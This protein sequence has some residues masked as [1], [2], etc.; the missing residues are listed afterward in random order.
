MNRNSLFIFS[1]AGGL[2][3]G[4]AWTSWCPGLVL[5]ISFTPFLLIGEHIYRKRSDYNSGCFFLCLLPGMLIF[6]IMTLGWVRAINMWSVFTVLILA[7]FLMSFTI[8]ISYMTRIYA[9]LIPS[10][11]MFVSSRM[12]LETLAANSAILSPWVN[13]GNGLAKD[14]LFIQWYDITGVS[15]G[16]LWILI[17]NILFA[18]LIITSFSH[19]KLNIKMLLIWLMVLFIPSIYSVLKFRSLKYSDSD[20]TGVLIVQPNFDPVS[21]KYTIPFIDQLQ[22]TIDMAASNIAT[23]T[24]WVITPE[25]IVDDPINEEDADNNIYIGMLREF[26]MQHPGVNIIAGL[27]TYRDTI[28]LMDEPP[29]PYSGSDTLYYNSAA[30]IDTGK[31]VEFYHKSKLVPGVEIEFHSIIGSLV[32]IIVPELGGTTW[33]YTKQSMISCFRHS[34]TGQVAGPIICYESVYGDYV[35]DYVRQGA[36]VLVIITNDGWWKNTNGYKHHLYYAS[37]RAIET[38]RPVVRA[39]N[40]GISCFIDIKGLRVSETGWWTREVLTGSIGSET[41]VTPYVLYGDYLYNFFSI[42]FGLAFLYTLG[43]RLHKKSL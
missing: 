35:R 21:E 26:A 31:I 13:L 2:L 17:S 18:V 20:K 39:A 30:K 9:G 28:G 27:V 32:N 36:E 23:D 3:S 33:G 22:T 43:N 25:T 7:T 8:W 14:I 11:L 16:S 34:A 4:L 41:T 40:T 10:I 19:K 1:V 24:R 6:N 38:R 12:A 15:G 42:V 29:G 37:L 5:L